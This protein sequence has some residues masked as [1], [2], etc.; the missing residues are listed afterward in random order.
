ME[1]DEM[2]RRLVSLTLMFIDALI[3][4]MVVYLAFWLRFEGEIAPENF[5]MI[6]RCLPM[7][8]VARLLIFFLFGLY[9]RMWR[10]ASVGELLA[11]AA[12]VSVST[13]L[14]IVLAI[15]FRQSF[16][17]SIYIISWFLNILLIGLSR[18]GVRIMAQLR[19]IP[20]NGQSRVL[21]VGAGHI[22]AMVA[23]EI[24]Q[25]HLQTKRI[26]GFVDDARAKQ[27][28]RLLGQKVLGARR[29][30]RRLTKEYHVDEIIVAI[31]TADGSQFSGII[32]DCRQTGC[33][34]RI[35][36]G[37]EKWVNGRPTLEQLREVRLEDLLRRAPVRRDLNQLAG[38]FRG[39]RV[40]V[41][42]AGGS[43]G[44]E[45]CR[46]IIRLQ[47]GGLI[48][49]G[50]GENS[51]YEIE[52]ELRVKYPETPL[53]PVI[54]DVRDRQ[55]IE[56]VFTRLRPEAVFHA[57]AHKHVP[58]MELQPEEAVQNNIF[59]AKVVA[60]AAH[61]Y[62]TEIFVM[63]STDKAVNPSSVMGTTKRVAEQVIKSLNQTSATK[64]V[65]VRFGNVLGSRGS[66]VP[67]FQKQI[68]SGGPVTVTHPEMKRY[69]MT[70][71]EAAQ[72]VLEAGVMARGGEV[73]VLDMGQPVKIYDLACTLIELAGLRPHQDIEIKYSG[74]RPGEKL[75]EELLS[76]EE[77]T[78]TTN[79]EQI[80]RANLQ[81]VD[82]QNLEEGL[83]LLRQCRF[84]QEIRKVLQG[85]VPTYSGDQDEVAVSAE[86]PRDAKID[87]ICDFAEIAQI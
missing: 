29:D 25:Y 8:I 61:T 41:T 3:A 38:Y 83:A 64:F 35:V 69:F 20:Q 10:Y 15:T 66:V 16:P 18:L 26:V 72:L 51:I 52:Q 81:A 33:R 70:I 84:S 56:A 2:R 79:H 55:R 36:P 14:T 80:F 31:A 60:E 32:R 49:L 30:L 62:G 28:Q 87:V 11:I 48:L 74:L 5:L 50:K 21:I 9:N 75:F 17:R 13:L 53:E 43:I 71:P 19:Y 12:A 42:G 47:P 59:G 37:L 22:G 4:A 73:F 7:M 58:L 86:R 45:L 85:L 76:A 34:V 6:N 1:V 82:P 23:R 54:A 27:G 39:K 78:S 67:L 77:G 65:A 44:S 68:A 24:Q 40:L 57:A 46:Q 63:I